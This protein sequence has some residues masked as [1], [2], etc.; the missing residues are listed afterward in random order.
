MHLPHARHADATS[1][2]RLS[3][4]RRRL[5]R[6]RPD[7][8]IVTCQMVNRMT[9]GAGDRRSR[10][11]PTASTPTT[12]PGPYRPGRATP[13]T[14][15]YRVTN[16]GNVHALG[17]R[18]HRQPAGRDG[19]LPGRHTSARA[20]MTCTAAGTAAPASTRTSGRSPRPTLRHGVND[21]RSLA[22]LRR[23]SRDRHREGHQR[24][25]RRPRARARS[26]R[27]AARSR[28]RTSSPTPATRRSAPSPSPTTGRAGRR[29]RRRRLAAGARDDLHRA[30]RRTA[31]PG[32]YENVAIRGRHR[33]RR[34]PGLRRLPLL[35][36][37]TRRSTIEKSTNG[38]D[39]DTA[40][41]PLVPVGDRRPGRYV[42]TNTG[43]VP[44]QLVGHRRSDH[45]AARLPAHRAHRPRASPST[46]RAAGIAQAG[47][48]ANI[49]T[50]V[51]T[52]PSGRTVTDDDPSHYFGV[53]AGRSTS[54][55]PPTARTPT[56]RPGRSSP[57]GGAGHLDLLV[58]NTGNSAADRRRGR[59]PTT[60]VAVTCPQIDARRRRVDDVH[61]HRHRRGRPVHQP[62]RRST[63]R[64]PPAGTA[65]RDADPSHYFGAAPGINIEKS[66]NG[67]DADD[68]PGPLIPVGEPGRVDL[69][70]SRNTRQRRRSPT[71]RSPTT[72]AS[73]SPA[74]TTTLAVGRGDDLHGYWHGRTGASTPTSARSPAPTRRA[75]RSP[76][77]TRRTTSASSRASTSRRPPTARTPT[78]RPARRSPS[79]TR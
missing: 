19:H 51:G 79:A 15:T 62:R 48:Y 73:P 78:S 31:G 44:L 13:V 72:R 8:S 5:H 50:V 58:T 66:T 25:R 18:R 30:G 16:T 46:C 2:C 38:Q 37:S 36:R 75:A 53:A 43:N 12:A 17:H 77:P 26:S 65:V 71:S 57:V 74:R 68:A 7:E 3:T 22:L 63:G 52:S 41:G 39:A 21:D 69:R 27:S 9:P 42:V 33:H 35:R 23:R 34:R 28:G 24:R 14:W 55:S 59:R 4:H 61:R 6:D 49:G 76:T 1:R 10:S 70:R 67:D 20:S 32:Q 60:G 29:A 54:R 64:R 11:R 45:D 56:S 47:Q 40:A